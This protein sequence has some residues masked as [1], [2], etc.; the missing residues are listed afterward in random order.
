MKYLQTLLLGLLS[1]ILIHSC[2]KKNSSSLTNSIL[3]TKFEALPSNTNNTLTDISFINENEG[4]ICGEFG[5]VA[6]TIDGGKSW[7]TLNTGT[8][9]YSFISAFMLDKNNYYIARNGLY[10]F[11]NFDASFT[12]LGSLSKNQARI[13]K[14]YFKDP[15]IGFVTQSAS[16]LKTV[17]GGQNWAEKYNTNLYYGVDN[18]QFTSTKIAYASGGRTFDATNEGEI[19]KTIDGGENWIKILNTINVTSISFISDEEGYFTTFNKEIFKTSDG[20]NNWLKISDIKYLPLSAVFLNNKTG[21]VATEEG[22]IL[23]T[24]NGGQTWEI[25]YE[26]TNVPIVKIIANNNSIYAIGG[27]GLLIKTN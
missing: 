15:L 25:V 11:K 18:L 3:E 10:L 4:I 26:K 24:I 22:K 17:D 7:I 27:D 20:G 21:Y 23:K 13:P 12:E 2:R 9:G 1:I 16:I 14:I 5:Y 19:I 6:K 8:I